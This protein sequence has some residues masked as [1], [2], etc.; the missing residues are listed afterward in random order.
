MQ[1]NAQN[2]KVV[3]L[4]AV[5]LLVA[6]LVPSGV[7][8]AQSKTKSSHHPATIGKPATGPAQ[9][10]NSGIKPSSLFAAVVANPGASNDQ[11]YAPPSNHD[12]IVTSLSI[13]F[14]LLSDNTTG[15]GEDEVFIGPP[16]CDTVS[17]VIRVASEGQ[18]IDD[19]MTF[20]DGV[21]I[22][23]GDALCMANKEAGDAYNYGSADGY[24]VKS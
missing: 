17:T 2:Q 15:E 10:V 16:G 1:K 22:P 5:T 18:I 8:I 21:E 20:P 23:S 19:E 12:A 11:L 13:D 7:A 4:I 6:I 9:V 24:T 14:A 3:W